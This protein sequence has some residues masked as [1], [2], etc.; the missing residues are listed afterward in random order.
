MKS[1]WIMGILLL[2]IGLI[3]I[4]INLPIRNLNYIDGGI[5][6]S[7]PPKKNGAYI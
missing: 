7:T 1:N 2:L 4:F 6:Y 5:V 3:W